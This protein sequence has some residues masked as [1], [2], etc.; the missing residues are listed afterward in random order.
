MKHNFEHVFCTSLNSNTYGTKYRL[1]GD[2]PA[3]D[4]N[5]CTYFCEDMAKTP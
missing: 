4:L 1:S 3:S 5:Q 2:K